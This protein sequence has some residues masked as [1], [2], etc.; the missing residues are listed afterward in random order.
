MSKNIILIATAVLALTAASCNK[1]LNRNP[2]VEETSQ[3]VY[4]DP[5]K[6]KEALAKLYGGLSLSGQG[7]TDNVDIS[8]PDA[9][10]NV[11]MRN[12]WEINELTTDEAVIA[13]GDGDLQQYH[14]M[15]WTAQ[16]PYVAMWYNR[17]FFEVAACNEFIRQ[18]PDSKINSFASGD[19]ANVRNYHN[20]A[21]FLRALAYWHAIDGFGNVPFTT[22]T[23]PVGSF[24]PKQK[25]RADLFKYVESELKDLETKLPDARTNEYGRVDKGCVWML[26][27]KLYLNATVYIGADHSADCITYCNKII[28]SGA[29]NLNSNYKYLFMTD[30]RTTSN[31]IIFPIRAN[32]KFSQS[33]GN[34]TFLI[35]AEIGGSMTPMN[36]GIGGGWAG[37]RT[38]KGLVSLFADPSGNTDKRALF[39]TNGQNLDITSITQ[40]GDGYA[41]GKFSNLSSTGAAGTDPAANFCDL[42]FPMFR[43]A[44]VLLM[45]AE[46]T[47][48]GG[49]GSSAT[50]LDYINQLRDR[51][52][53]N[54][55]GEIAA[56]D[57]T[58][59]F[60]LDERGR[61]LY[62]EG[63]RRT[64][65]IRFGKFTGSAYL[66]P[67][68][69]GVKDGADVPAYLALFPIPRTDLTANPGL[70]QNTG[71]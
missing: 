35:H 38:T 24:T 60:I 26:L 2:Y 42:D 41:I 32:G 9:G 7:T 67:W 11:Y 18:T 47:L 55:S 6:I 30:N 59:P 69:G 46:A 19:A 43:Y 10:S 65:L 28:Q 16:N 8:S 40:F 36:W 50:A 68:K 12:W 64:D 44:D 61:E 1:D 34:S 39:Y 15:G 4:S 58:L 52:Y 17:I 3:S 56:S 22:E 23:D 21:R 54:T 53:G 25:S 37:L 14:S 48:R 33:Y 20:E 31:E 62:W 13:W 49:G 71:Y 70:T 27:A 5:V 63:Q 51:A 45:Y 57:L 66:W 29:Y